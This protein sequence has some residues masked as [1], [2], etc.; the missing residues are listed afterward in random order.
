[1]TIRLMFLGEISLFILRDILI[2]Q[3]HSVGLVESSLLLK[4]VAR[5]IKIVYVYINNVAGRK[6]GGLRF[7]I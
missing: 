6:C 1:M 3:M 7:L 2:Q 5:L 4:Q